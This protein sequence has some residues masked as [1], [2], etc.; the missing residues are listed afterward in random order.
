MPIN[1]QVHEGTYGG[2][3][4]RIFKAARE[5]DWAKVRILAE[6]DAAGRC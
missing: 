1:W 4:R 2:C 5:Q 6:D 3:G